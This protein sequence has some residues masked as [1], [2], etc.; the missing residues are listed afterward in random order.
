[1][2]EFD[3]NK[4]LLNKKFEGYKYN[5]NKMKVKKIK[6]GYN[7]KE[8]EL[9][10]EYYDYDHLKLISMSNYIYKNNFN[11]LNQ[12]YYISNEGY[13]VLVLIVNINFVR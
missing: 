2:F 1:M 4:T 10:E 7:V 3:I 13:I 5:S 12:I 11:E 6:N 9:N 8:F